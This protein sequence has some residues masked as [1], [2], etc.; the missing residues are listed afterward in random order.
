MIRQDAVMRHGR[1]LTSCS[2]AA[3][4]L[5][6]GPGGLLNNVMLPALLR[7]LDAK[8][9]TPVQ[10]AARLQA[11]RMSYTVLYS[12]G[13]RMLGSTI[14]LR[15]R[16]PTLEERLRF[17]L[18]LRCGERTGLASTSSSSSPSSTYRI[19]WRVAGIWSSSSSSA[20]DSIGRISSWL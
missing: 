19:T 16:L 12:M 9:A 3:R 10:S 2:L 5:P 8:R 18:R 14:P 1:I 7:F 11:S 4:L 13:S 15:T 20:L 6:V 17:A